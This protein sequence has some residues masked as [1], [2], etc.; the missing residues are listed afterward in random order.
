MTTT[1]NPLEKTIA[2]ISPMLRKFA[3]HRS[4]THY[5]ADLADMAPEAQD[6]YQ[7]A[8]LEILK[9]CKPEDSKA[10]LL[11]LANWRM[12]N[13][14]NRETAYAGLSIDEDGQEDGDNSPEFLELIPA[15]DDDPEAIVIAAEQAAR[16]RAIADRLPVD[17]AIVLRL[18]RDGVNLPEI[19][20][21][22][23]ITY[24]LAW[25]RLVRL[26]AAFQLAGV[27]IA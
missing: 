19:A 14:A 21:R 27:T 6:L 3:A 7:Q 18:L 16:I 2:E 5:A 1:T 23:G 8:V 11:N 22:L 25:K 24:D 4:G 20:R 12:L 9:T 10:Y 26:R 15:C 17:Q 13:I